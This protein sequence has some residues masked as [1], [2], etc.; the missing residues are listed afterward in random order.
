MAFFNSKTYTCFK[1]TSVWSLIMTLLIIL[2][3]FSLILYDNA[4]GMEADYVWFIPVAFF[5]VLSVFFSLNIAFLLLTI[6]REYIFREKD[7]TLGL[8]GKF[9]NLFNKIKFVWLKRLI[10]FISMITFVLFL[11]E[12]VAICWIAII[13]F[14]VICFIWNFI[15][16]IIMKK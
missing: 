12:T 5:F 3:L 1:I 15:S 7:F 2:L 11:I 13:I 6:V 16:S 8:I 10:I 9:D 14:C 4:Y